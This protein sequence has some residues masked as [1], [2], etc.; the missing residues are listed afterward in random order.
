MN[1]H[2]V[3]DFLFCYL[4]CQESGGRLSVFHPL[5]RFVNYSSH[6]FLQAEHFFSPSCCLEKKLVF[7]DQSIS[8]CFYLLFANIFI[9]LG[10][11]LVTSSISSAV[12]TVHPVSVAL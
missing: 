8:V 5:Q 11:L 2:T 6:I 3:I 7:V 1:F 4:G 10:N 12:C 9:F